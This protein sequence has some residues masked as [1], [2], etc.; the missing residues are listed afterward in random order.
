MSPVIALEAINTHL[1]DDQTERYCVVLAKEIYCIQISNSHS[2]HSCQYRISEQRYAVRMVHSGNCLGVHSRAV[3]KA[4]GL[5]M[6]SERLV[7]DVLV[8]CLP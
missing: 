1:R 4:H 6:V 8:L 5:Q 2:F 7:V 3:G